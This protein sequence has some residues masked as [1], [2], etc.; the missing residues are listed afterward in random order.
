VA[1]RDLV[2]SSQVLQAAFRGDDSVDADAGWLLLSDGL[3]CL[4]SVRHF[5]SPKK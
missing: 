2:A 4:R 3:A 5:I 1:Q